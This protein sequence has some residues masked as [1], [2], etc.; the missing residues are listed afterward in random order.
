MLNCLEFAVRANARL[1]YTSFTASLSTLIDSKENSNGWITLTPN[2]M[3]LKDGYGQS[4]AV[5]EQLLCTASSL[6]ADIVI[7]RPCAIS[8]DTQTGYSNISDF[9]NSLLRAEIEMGGT[10]ENADIQLHLVP[11]DYCS[12]A[13]VALAM[14]S[15]SSE[16]CFNFYGNSL[17][18]S[19]LHNAGVQQLPGV[20]TKKIEQNNWKQYVLK[21][22]PENS[23]ACRIKDQI[24]SMIFTNGNIQ[25]VKFGVPIQMTKDFLEKKCDLKWFEVTEQDLIKSVEYMINIGFLSR[26]SS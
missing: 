24:A 16:H 19:C 3:S 25:Q 12:K 22:L 10:V 2:D 7:N 21:N 5:V 26:R 20:I 23:L 8:G 4:K 17:S 18:I 1:V 9:I 6:C 11:V 14:H 13:I 15:D